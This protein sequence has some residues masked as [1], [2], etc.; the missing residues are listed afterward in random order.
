VV[1]TDYVTPLQRHTLCTEVHHYQ[2]ST[3]PAGRLIHCHIEWMSDEIFE[4][5]GLLVWESHGDRPQRLE[6]AGWLYEDDIKEREL[7]KKEY[8]AVRAALA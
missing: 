6:R 3:F 4:L 7:T 2:V 5:G 8:R 1:T